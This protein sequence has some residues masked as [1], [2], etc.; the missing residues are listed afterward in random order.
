MDN[1][2]ILVV[3]DN[4]TDVRLI[5]EALKEPGRENNVSVVGNGEEALL[6]LKKQGQYE[7]VPEPDV[8]LLDLN[9]PKKSG[10]EILKEIKNDPAL[11]HI[12]VVVLSSSDSDRDV[13]QSYELNASVHLVK[14][15]DVDDFF[16]TVR[17]VSKLWFEKAKYPRK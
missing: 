7:G 17:S 13:V 10:H 4:P 6:F 9:L 15:F 16:D 14:P 8:V 5:L 2:N 1:I 12:P 11:R 3:E